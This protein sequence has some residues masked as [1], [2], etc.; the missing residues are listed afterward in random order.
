MLKI[1]LIQLKQFRGK[2][3]PLI[4]GWA[5]ECNWLS[6][7]R[8]TEVLPVDHPRITLVTIKHS[9]TQVLPDD[10]DHPTR[11]HD[12]PHIPNNH[13]TQVLP[14]NHDDQ[15]RTYQPLG[16]TIER[17][18]VKVRRKPKTIPISLQTNHTRKLL[19]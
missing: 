15:P 3:I 6:D 8:V 14:N 5:V 17:S 9:V 12:H 11:S 19:L 18:L 10:I 2:D 7:G 13:L 4:V 1:Y 16:K